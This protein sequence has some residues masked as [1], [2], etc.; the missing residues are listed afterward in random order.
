MQTIPSPPPNKKGR[1][2]G[3]FYLAKGESNN[4]NAMRMS[5]AREGLT[6]RNLYLRL[7][8]KCKRFPSPPPV[9]KA[10]DLVAFIIGG[11]NRVILIQPK[12]IIKIKVPLRKELLSGGYAFTGLQRNGY[13][14]RTPPGWA[15][16]AFPWVEM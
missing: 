16:S 13:R 14:Y 12:Q 2:S 11:E 9:I 5:I 8:R 15:S 7:C 3:L 10:T 4:L 1:S 6:E